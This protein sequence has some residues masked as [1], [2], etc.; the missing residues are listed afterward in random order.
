MANDSAWKGYGVKKYCLM[1]SCLVNNF[2]P[3]WRLWH[4]YYRQG[5]HHGQDMGVVSVVS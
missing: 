4:H 5:H 3:D 2:N 1:I